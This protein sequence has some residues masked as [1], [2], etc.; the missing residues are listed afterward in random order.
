[1]KTPAIIEAM[2]LVDRGHF[3]K[4]NA[5]TDSPQSIGYAVTI[6]APHMVSIFTCQVLDHQ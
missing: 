4:F 6:S 1:L 3:A 5:Y 2:K